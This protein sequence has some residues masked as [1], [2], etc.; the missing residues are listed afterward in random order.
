MTSNKLRYGGFAVLFIVSFLPS[1]LALAQEASPPTRIDLKDFECVYLGRAN[2]TSDWGLENDTQL[3]MTKE[4]I[5]LNGGS[6]FR[7]TGIY[8][9]FVKLLA[10]K[11]RECLPIDLNLLP[12]SWTR[13]AWKRSPLKELLTAFDFGEGIQIEFIADDQVYIRR[14][15]WRDRSK[16]L[17]LPERSVYRI[18]GTELEMAIDFTQSPASFFPTAAF[19]QPI[20]EGPVYIVERLD[21]PNLITVS[22]VSLAKKRPII[23]PPRSWKK[24]EHKA[25]SERQINEPKFSFVNGALFSITYQQPEQ[26][27]TIISMQVQKLGSDVGKATKSSAYK[28]QLPLGPRLKSTTW[29]QGNSSYDGRYFNTDSPQSIYHSLKAPNSDTQTS[30]TGIL[31]HSTEIREIDLETCTETRVITPPESIVFIGPPKFQRNRSIL[32]FGADCRLR[33]TKQ[34]PVKFIL[35]VPP[36][37]EHAEIVCEIPEAISPIVSSEKSIVAAQAHIYFLGRLPLSLRNFERRATK[38]GNLALY[39]F[40]LNKTA[41]RH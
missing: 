39:R 23:E 16:K 6:S 35:K 19:R 17:P 8:S 10:L 9:P 3:Y 2:G 4:R 21:R 34:P 27:N 24:P 33:K 12:N 1:K 25:S 14:T 32:I 36:G 29:N 15:R 31:H 5:F 28:Y 41:S 26:A 37:A 7:N 20:T 22:S 13:K 30:R 38:H 40:P 11:K 18:N